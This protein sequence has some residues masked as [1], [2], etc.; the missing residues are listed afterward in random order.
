[1]P[2]IIVPSRFLTN[3]SIPDASSLA[4][5]VATK[6]TNPSAMSAPATG[7]DV[8]ECTGI[9]FVKSF[10]PVDFL[11]QQLHVR[12]HVGKGD[13]SCMYHTVAHQAELIPANCKGNS[14]ISMALRRV[15]LVMMYKYPQVCQEDGL[16]MLQ[17]LEKQLDI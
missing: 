1:M 9:G 4:P 17:W 7:K 2:Y 12:K 13:G 14:D 3:K 10:I 5:S 6:S 15:A 8:L 11:L 16:S